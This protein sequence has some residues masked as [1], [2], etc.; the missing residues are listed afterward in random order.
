MIL[1][2]SFNDNEKE[3]Y[4][5]DPQ[6]YYKQGFDYIVEVLLTKTAAPATEVLLALAPCEVDDK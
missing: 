6:S 4:K 2:C 3:F 1:Y 5:I